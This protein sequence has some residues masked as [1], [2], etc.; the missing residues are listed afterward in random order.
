MRKIAIGLSILLMLFIL[1]VAGCNRQLPISK[2]SSVSQSISTNK[3]LF[4]NKSEIIDAINSQ[5]NTIIP[6]NAP[7]TLKWHTESISFLQPSYVLVSYSE[8]H[9]VRIALFLVN[10]KDKEVM[11]DLILDGQ[12]EGKLPPIVW[13]WKRTQ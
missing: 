5:I 9:M 10:I 13:D 7:P 6:F 1:L 12:Q 8:G 11:F 3:S 2:T 4:D